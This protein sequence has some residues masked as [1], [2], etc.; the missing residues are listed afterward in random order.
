M[1]KIIELMKQGGTTEEIKISDAA[2]SQ[3]FGVVVSPVDEALYRF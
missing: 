1:G 2:G 3:Y